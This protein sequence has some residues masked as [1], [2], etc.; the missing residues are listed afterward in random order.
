MNIEMGKKIKLLRL[1]KGMTQEVLAGR[2]NMSSQAVSKWENS[3]TLPDI[4]ILPELSVLLGVTIDELFALP[5]D[6]HLERIG[7]MI[8]KEQSISAEDFRYA[9]SFLKE[10]L[11][12]TGKTAQCL[13]LL[14]Q[15][16]I[17][18]VEEHRG[19]AS[20]YAKEALIHA[21]DSKDAHNALRDA[22]NGPVF[23]WN[24]SNH[25]KLIGYYKSFVAEHPDHWRSYV[26]LLN[27]LIA[28]GRCAE[29]RGMLESLNAIR[30]GYLYQL[31]GGLICKEEGN[32]TQALNLWKQMTELY[33][34][35]W[36]AWSARGDCMA[37]LGRYDEAIEYYA[38][39][40]DLQP[41]PVWKPYRISIRFRGNTWKL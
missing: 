27:Y 21:P 26:W 19:L 31:Y 7:I 29:A 16:H 30:P 25:H 38:R 10:K 2:L 24:C 6:T 20:H 17:H 32:L 22:E 4:Q 33:P 40:D 41:R 18:R 35:D 12:D 36:I 9:E 39:G 13:T 8:S 1:Q 5:D 23:D 15:L 11:S 28:D 3:V 37:K 34:E 14:A